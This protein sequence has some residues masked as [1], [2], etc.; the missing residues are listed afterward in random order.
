MQIETNLRKN[1]R[2]NALFLILIAVALFAALS[3]AVT[4]SG[5]GGGTVDRE[6]AMI[7]ASQITQ[8]P[9]MLR[10]A[11]TRMVLTGTA[12]TTVDYDTAGTTSV[13]VFAT[14]GG[15][16]VSQ[17]PPN[18]IGSPKGGADGTVV[19]S[20]GY[21]DLLHATNGY[22][23]HAVGT[24]TNVSGRESFAFIRDISL[25]V[26]QQILRGLGLSTTVQSNAATLNHATAAG[27][28]EATKTA[29]ATYNA[30]AGVAQP[31]AC[32]ING[33]TVYDY[34]HA[35]IEQ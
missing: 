3:Y 17:A 20:W 1:E 29:T 23:I 22:Y 13:H 15:G 21:K 32:V 24:D 2:G 26:C 33:A 34:Y 31:F 6:T 25:T 27:T 8:Y 10:T 12:P 9:A 4:Q 14:V 16:A 5:R 7:A 35:L 18:N 30:F 19:N 28:G 11:V